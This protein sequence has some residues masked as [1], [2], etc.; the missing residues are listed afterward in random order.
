MY[1]IK[2]FSIV[3]F[4]SLHLH[5]AIGQQVNKVKITVLSTMLA[6]TKVNGVSRRWWNATAQGFCLTLVSFRI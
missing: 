1:K 6:D 4:V 2:T 5:E 3:L